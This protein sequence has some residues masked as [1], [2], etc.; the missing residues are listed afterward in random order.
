M[1]QSKPEDHNNSPWRIPSEKAGSWMAFFKKFSIDFNRAA[2]WGMHCIP[3]KQEHFI[4][5][6]DWNWGNWGKTEEKIIY[7]QIMRV[8]KYLHV[9]CQWHCSVLG[10]LLAE[11][12]KMWMA[13]D[14]F[15]WR[16]L[17]LGLMHNVENSIILQTSL[18]GPII[19][20]KLLFFFFF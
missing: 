6:S 19:N 14:C 10:C 1:N 20:Q 3:G 11:N 18:A 12:M 2:L 16:L 9:E 4:S 8:G 13:Q 17:T 7:N 5:F 15:P